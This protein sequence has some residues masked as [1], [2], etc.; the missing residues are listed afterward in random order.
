MTAVGGEETWIVKSAHDAIVGI[1]AAGVI[2]YC[3]PAA[4][5]LYDYPL[6]QLV[7]RG[8]EMLLPLDRQAE[9]AEV[10][11]RIVAGGEVAPYRA[12]RVR[13]DGTIIAVSA[14][15][16]PIVDAAGTI[17][18]AAA[19]ARRA[20]MQDA[21]DRFE[22]RVDQQRGEAQDAADRFEVRVDQQREETRDAAARFERRVSAERVQSQDTE[23]GFQDRMD[24][25]RTQARSDQDVLR[26]QLQ[27]GQ[28]L[29]IL[30]Q[31]AGGVAHDSN[32]LLAVIL[33]HTAFVADELALGPE[34]DLVTAGRDVGQI[35]RAV[36]RA[37][38]LTHQLLAFARREV[39]QPRVLDLNHVVSDM[40][41]LLHRTLG[42]DLVL[43]TELAEDLWP[44]LA[45]PGQSRCS[46]T[47]PST[48]A[49]R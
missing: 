7:G 1:D 38:G 20:T 8:A 49:T 14:T 2:T 9:E 32:N 34:A 17:I 37:A 36:E 18:G 35:Q 22:A 3:N 30:G 15:I 26:G 47:S 12:D 23:D 48:P 5:R 39:V 28:R 11:R 16:W 41:E 25:Q 10:L 31:L 13:R 27:Q 4:A 24:A 44:V 19:M 40:Q 33:N 46:P 29:E 6:E 45:D 42:A 43:Q 21:H